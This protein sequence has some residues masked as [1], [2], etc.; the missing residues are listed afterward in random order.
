M[1]VALVNANRIRP[2]IAPIGLEYVAEA[3]AAAGHDVDVLDLCWEEEPARE[4][5]FS[6][7][8]RV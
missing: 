2:P 8:N 4:C 1:R 5:R 6:R 3:V 7:E